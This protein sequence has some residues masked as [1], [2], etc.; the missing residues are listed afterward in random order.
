MSKVIVEIEDNIC[1]ICIN[2]AEKKNALT[3]A[4]YM[5]MGQAI[6]HAQSDAQ[7]KVILIRSEGE[8]FSA[9]NDMFDFANADQSASEGQKIG[10]SFNFMNAL[11]N[12]QLPVVAQV[13][14]LAV[15]IGTTLL[16]HCDI[17]I[18]AD[19]A[20]FSMPFIDLALVPEFASSYLVPKMAG[21]RKAS[22]WL[23]LGDSFGAQEAEKFGFVSEVQPIEHLNQRVSQVT[24]ALVQKPKTA[25]LNSKKLMKAD[26]SIV[27]EKMQNEMDIFVEMLKTPAAKEAFTAFIEKRSLDRRVYQ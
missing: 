19:S 2:R 26:S 23:L 21:H 24:K 16:L 11:K 17:V 20:R 22:K 27:T 4:M 9:G 13:Q 3:Q 18:C 10:D 5:E 14:G 1:V 7:V 8:I 12:S 6:N 15:G 25:L